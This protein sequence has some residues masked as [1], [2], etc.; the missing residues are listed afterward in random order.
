M[1]QVIILG[2][3]GNCLDIAEAIEDIRQHNMKTGVE[4]DLMC[5]GFLDDCRESWGTEFGGLPILGPLSTARD[6]PAA[7]F[8]NGIGSPGNFWKKGG[9]IA[10]TGLGRERFA[11]I[12]HPTAVVSRSA[13]LGVGVVIFPL[14]TITSN[15]RLGDHVMVLPQS[16]ISHDCVVGDY[17]AIAGAVCVSGQVEIGE[18]CYL[19]SGCLVRNGIR[20]GARTLVGMGS[21]VTRDVEANQIVVGNPARFLRLTVEDGASAGKEREWIKEA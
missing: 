17:T 6:F 15:A 8:V 10:Q 4:P 7:H 19:G 11:N 21:V 3:G 9:I 1:K 5:T 13:R 18:S 12:V 16:V 2:T 14:V 20:I